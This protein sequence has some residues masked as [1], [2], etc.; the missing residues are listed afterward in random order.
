MSALSDKG[1]H[2]IYLY[3]PIF[4]FRCCFL[5]VYAPHFPNLYLLKV[6]NVLQPG[7]E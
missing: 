1:L 7:V 2:N 4:M 3:C 6:C 5:Y